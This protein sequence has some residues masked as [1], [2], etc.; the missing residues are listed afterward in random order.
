MTWQGRNGRYRE[1]KRRVSVAVRR[2]R[3]NFRR[4]QVPR[5]LLQ[6]SKSHRKMDEGAR[7]CDGY[8]ICAMEEKSHTLKRERFSTTLSH[9]SD[10]VVASTSG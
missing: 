7:R 2:P 1:L 5:F 6:A 8:S 4:R 9:S 10:R 3:A